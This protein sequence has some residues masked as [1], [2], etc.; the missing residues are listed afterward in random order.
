MVFLIPTPK[1]ASFGSVPEFSWNALEDILLPANY[2]RPLLLA[3]LNLADDF[4]ALTGTRIRFACGEAVGMPIRLEISA[5]IKGIDAYRLRGDSKGILLQAPTETGLFYGIQTLRQLLRQGDTRYPAFDIQD[6]AD[7]PNRG[8]YQ[9]ATRGAIPTLETLFQLVDKMAF[10]KLNHLELYIEHTFALAKHPDIWEGADPLTAEE[11]LR[12]QDYCNE[13]NIDLVPS[14]ATFGHCYMA[15]RSKRLEDLNELD[16]K[17]SEFPFSF[18]DRMQHATL[19][20][21]DPRSIKL[22]ADILGEFLPLFK[23]KYCNICGDETFDLGR[24]KNKHL[25]KSEE[26]IQKLYMTFLKKIMALVTKQG[27]IP[28]FWGDV[29]GDNSKLLKELPKDV[30]PLEWDYGPEATR[31]DTAK[32]AAATPNFWVVPGTGC[33]SRWLTPIHIAYK[34]ILNYAKKGLKYHAKGLL[35]TNW[36]DRGNVNLPAISWHGFAYGA[37]C[38]WNTAASQDIDAFNKALDRLEFGAVGFCDAWM[39][40]EK[41]TTTA[42]GHVAQWVDPTKESTFEADYADSIDFAATRKAIP[43]LE[44]AYVK[45]SNCLANAHPQDPYAREELLFG[46]QMTILMHKVI[47]TI[48]FPNDRAANWKLADDIRHQEVQFCQLWHRRNKPSEYYR[49]KGALL[50]V[51]RKLDTL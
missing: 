50:D 28:M 33:W 51:A 32:L 8:F 42:W 43:V 14:I 6:A 10:Y 41:L 25:V 3:A 13:R 30:I 46:A 26:D 48:K 49:I 39:K 37:A 38:A 18:R 45:F 27:K 15:M 20:P 12:L 5:K 11:I 44:K 4:Q 47:A 22:V 7:Y 23:S 31:R 17:G 40:F 2:G 34:N 21:S 29:I 36:G 16:V 24:G 19:N 9:D 1:K 35:N